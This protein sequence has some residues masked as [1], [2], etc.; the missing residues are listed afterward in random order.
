MFRNPTELMPPR[1]VRLDLQMRF[2]WY[3]YGYG[4]GWNIPFNGAAVL[5]L[6]R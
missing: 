4:K 2:D 1:L 6:A 5:R 3:R